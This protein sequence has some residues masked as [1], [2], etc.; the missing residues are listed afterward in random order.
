MDLSSTINAKR[1]YQSSG[2]LRSLSRESISLFSEPKGKL[3]E[4][5]LELEEQKL[6]AIED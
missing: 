4:N 3:Q 5:R 2:Y 1:S 6:S